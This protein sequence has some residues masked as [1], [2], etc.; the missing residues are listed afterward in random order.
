M[1]GDQLVLIFILNKGRENIPHDQTD[2]AVKKLIFLSCQ[3]G[4]IG[5]CSFWE[6]DGHSQTQ[7]HVVKEQF[8][9]QLVLEK[10]NLGKAGDRIH[11]LG[12]TI[13][14]LTVKL[15][16]KEGDFLPFDDDFIQNIGKI[17]NL[18]QI[19]K[20]PLSLGQIRENPLGEVQSFL[21]NID[22]RY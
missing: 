12:N 11:H 4:H 17:N 8:K 16:S 7:P 1:Q 9:E 10:I 22:S 21:G 14:K 15:L 3:V 19:V 2:D 13:I 18:L 6:E 5:C 20:L